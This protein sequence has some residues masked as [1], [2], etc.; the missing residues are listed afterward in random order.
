MDFLYEEIAFGFLEL[1]F[2]L[3]D[4]LEEDLNVLEMF[5][6]ILAE[7]DNVIQIGHHKITTVCKTIEIYCWK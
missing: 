2:S 5:L 3:F 6:F 1:E 7:D 4:L